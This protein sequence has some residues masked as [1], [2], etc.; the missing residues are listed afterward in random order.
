M[1]EEWR[2][3]EGY[4]GLY[5]VSS[6]GRVRSLDR[7]ITRNG[8]S[9]LLKGKIMTASYSGFHRRYMF[10]VLSKNCITRQF[11]VHRLVAKAF[12][13][14]PNNYPQVNHRDGNPSNNCVENLEWCTAEYNLTYNDRH[15]KVGKKEK[16]KKAPNAKKVKIYKNGEWFASAFSALGAADMVGVTDATVRQNIY[17]KTHIIKG[18]YTFEYL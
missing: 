15:I 12:I 17:G 14:N 9:A 6:K 1:E 18:E 13:P 5:Q 10:I 16:G 3:I 8:K 4:E 7:Y 11:Y 2:D